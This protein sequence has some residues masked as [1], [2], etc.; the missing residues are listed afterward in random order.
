M[1]SIPGSLCSILEMVKTEVFQILH[2]IVPRARQIAASPC[3]ENSPRLWELRK[4]RQACRQVARNADCTGVGIYIYIY[5][6]IYILHML[7]THRYIYIYMYMYMY[8]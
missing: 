7:H 6:Y 1:E 2:F 5:I 4:N 3:V 8:L